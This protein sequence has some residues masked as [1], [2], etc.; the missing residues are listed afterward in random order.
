MERFTSTN[1]VEETLNTIIDRVSLERL[2]EGLDMA[3]SAVAGTAGLAECDQ[4]NALREEAKILDAM[5]RQI[6]L[7]DPIAAEIARL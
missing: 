5:Y 7:R 4:I 2:S 1:D 3:L 6:E